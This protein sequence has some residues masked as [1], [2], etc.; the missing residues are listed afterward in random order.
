ETTLYAVPLE[1]IAG[2]ASEAELDAYAKAGPATAGDFRH[3][4]AIARALDLDRLGRADDRLMSYGS[5]GLFAEGYADR[6]GVRPIDFAAISEDVSHAWLA[7]TDGP[8]HPLHGHTA[9]DADRAGGYTWCKA[10][11]LDGAT[12]EV[13]ALAR[14]AVGGHPLVVDLV[15]LSGSNVRSRVIGRLVELAR[16]VIFMEGAARSLRPKE[17]FCAAPAPLPDEASGVGLVEAARGSLGHWL[18][19]RN[20]RIL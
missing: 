2:L 12:V 3:F 10:P 11:R 13:G 14:Q 16:L 15:R 8:Q 20:G 19:I 18:R 4:L 9:P 1:A 5:F 17:P 6:A 7:P